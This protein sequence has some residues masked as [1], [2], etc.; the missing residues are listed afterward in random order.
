MKLGKFLLAAALILGTTTPMMSAG[1][2]R[3]SVGYDAEFISSGK[4]QTFSGFSIKFMHGWGIVKS[5]PLYVDAGLRMNANFNTVGKGPEKANSTLLAVSLP[6]NLSYKQRVAS[7]VSIQPY[8]GFNFKVNCL[9][10]TT[11]AG[12]GQSWF[13]E[14]DSWKRFQMGWQIGLGANISCFYLGLEYGIDFIKLHKDVSSSHVEVS[15]G[16]NF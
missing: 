13:S 14:P 1:F 15:L 7:G 6:F 8:T 12:I 5:L 16:Y 9:G 11:I 10:K 2:G 4:S 3:I